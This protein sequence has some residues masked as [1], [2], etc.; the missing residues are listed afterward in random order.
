M[1]EKLEK[2][3]KDKLS[4]DILVF[5][6]QNQGS[7][8]SVGGISTWVQRSREDVRKALEDLVELGVLSKDST[9]ATD[10]YCY[11]RDEK[12]MNIVNKLLKNV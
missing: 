4:K 9:G 10:G 6:Y 7:I 5:F 2:V 8:D 1:K 11:T 3:L 12:I